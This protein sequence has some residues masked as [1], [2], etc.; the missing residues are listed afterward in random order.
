MNWA[1]LKTIVW[2]RWRLGFNQLRRT[3]NLNTVLTLGFFICL[4]PSSALL[5]ITTLTVGIFVLPMASADHVFYVWCGIIIAF[6][7]MWCMGL[8]VELQRSDAISIDK[9]LHLPISLSG[10]FLVN[11]LGSLASISL[12]VFAPSMFALC[13]AMVI[14]KGAAALVMFPL[15][16]GFLLMTTATTFQLRGWLSAIMQNKRHR[17]IVLA[18][19]GMSFL[20]LAQTPNLVNI[21]FWRNAHNNSTA[22]AETYAEA[23]RVYQGRIKQVSQ[24]LTDLTAA[25][26]AG[27]VEA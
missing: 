27:D 11:Y 25:T 9:I 16:A 17:R 5:F 19:M 14:V 24:K 26:A 22:H 2:L 18:G 20:L 21:L 6:L 7:F 8:M 1:H 23:A 4:L 10:A 13:L 12:I 3:G 15:L